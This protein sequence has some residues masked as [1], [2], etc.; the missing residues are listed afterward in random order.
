MASPHA[1]IEAQALGRLAAAEVAGDPGRKWG[2]PET[3]DAGD[4]SWGAV[5][6]RSP[7]HT[8]LG[9]PPT[10][11]YESSDPESDVEGAVGGGGV[12][13]P[14]LFSDLHLRSLIEPLPSTSISDAGAS[15]YA[16]AHER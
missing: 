5:S 4:D 12:A 14:N 16:A 15:R 1:P 6:G 3:A 13:S 7:S 2:R 9:S 11:D 10:S 8:P